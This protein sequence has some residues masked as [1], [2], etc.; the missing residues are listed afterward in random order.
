[1]LVSDREVKVKLTYWYFK[2]T[3]PLSFLTFLRSVV[4]STTKSVGVS[5]QPATMDPIQQQIFSFLNPH[6][7]ALPESLIRAIA[8][9]FIPSSSFS[10]LPLTTSQET[11]LSSSNTPPVRPSIPSASP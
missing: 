11:L 3:P 1:V 10:H 6:R 2:F 5:R 8:G 4:D 7:R 9:S